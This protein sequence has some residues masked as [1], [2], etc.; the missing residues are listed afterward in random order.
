MNLHQK[1]TRLTTLLSQ[2]DEQAFNEIYL[3]YASQMYVYAFNILN[4]KAV[5]E[6]I[7]QNIFIDLWI[8]RAQVNIKNLSSYLFRAVKFQVFNH[9]RNKHFSNEE[10]KRLNIIDIS[11]DASE[12]MEFDEFEKIILTIIS[13]LPERR[14]EIF[15]LSRFENKS[16]KEIAELLKISV[17][18]VKKPNFKGPSKFKKTARGKGNRQFHNHIH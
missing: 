6:D 4:K 10:L 1:D 5:C 17:Q 15:L 3:R 13:K 7:V 2:S 12:K 18:G 11:Y 9:F 14:R 16:N 8:R